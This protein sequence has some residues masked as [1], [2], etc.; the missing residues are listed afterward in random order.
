[1]AAIGGVAC[2]RDPTRGGGGLDSMTPMILVGLFHGLS[3]YLLVSSIYWFVYLVCHPCMHSA[4]LLTMCRADNERSFVC[5]S[6]IVTAPSIVLYPKH[7]VITSLC[8][9]GQRGIPEASTQRGS[10][11]SMPRLSEHTT[12][13]S[14]MLL[15]RGLLAITS[16]S[17]RNWHTAESRPH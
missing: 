15:R 13:K 16:K 14:P 1:M 9:F 12:W 3:V 17:A 6:H 5:L 11:D 8:C 4:H 7:C 10:L 2:Q